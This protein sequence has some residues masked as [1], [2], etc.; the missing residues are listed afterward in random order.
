MAP[1]GDKS[2][3]NSIVHNGFSLMEGAHHS[4]NTFGRIS[5]LLHMNFEVRRWLHRDTLLLRTK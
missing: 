3:F 4:I 2:A 5:Q 1:Q